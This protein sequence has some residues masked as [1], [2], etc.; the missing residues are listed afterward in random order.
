MSNV[1][2]APLNPDT[3]VGQFRLAYGDTEFTPFD[4]EVEG[5]GNYA[6][7]S[8]VEIKTFLSLSSGSVPRAI[9]TYYRR[10]AGDAAKK[11]ISVKDHDLSA[12]LTKRASNLLEAAAGWDAIA[13]SAGEGDI[14]EIAGMGCLCDLEAAP[15]P[16][17]RCG[18]GPLIF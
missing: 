6:E 1:G 15:Y 13:D 8:D 18:C 4:P 11:S 16:V 7:L 3:P 12:D 17:G 5:S 10:L 9:A 14:F 2:V